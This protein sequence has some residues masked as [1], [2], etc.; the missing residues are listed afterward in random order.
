MCVRMCA[1]LYTHNH[2]S[3][4]KRLDHPWL[5]TLKAPSSPGLGISLP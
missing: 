2:T 4:V 5:F 1:Y 3:R